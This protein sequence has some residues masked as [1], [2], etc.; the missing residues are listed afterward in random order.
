[1]EVSGDKEPAEGEVYVFTTGGGF[2]VKGTAQDVSRRLSEEEWAHF[3]LAESGD[4]VLIRA[5]HV[6]ALRTGT[7]PK[8]GSIG[9]V[10][11]ES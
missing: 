1:M 4:P 5:A 8:R 2:V 11:P 9:F 7:K 6:I 10:H 3:E